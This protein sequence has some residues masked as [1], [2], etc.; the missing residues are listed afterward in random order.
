MISFCSSVNSFPWRAIVSMQTINC[1]PKGNNP[2]N[3][4]KQSK[5]YKTINSDKI[6]LDTF[7]IYGKVLLSTFQADN[8]C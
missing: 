4:T 3:K 1:L 8:I 6:E 7:M 2:E 5:N